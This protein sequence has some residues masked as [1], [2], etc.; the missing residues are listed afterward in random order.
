MRIRHSKKL[1]HLL[2]EFDQSLKPLNDLFVVALDS[3]IAGLHEVLVLISEELLYLGW[4]IVECLLQG[5]HQKLCSI[6]RFVN[7]LNQLNRLGKFSVSLVNAVRL[8]V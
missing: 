2:D 7:R 6:C 3:K 4:L 5:Q 8:L 1:N